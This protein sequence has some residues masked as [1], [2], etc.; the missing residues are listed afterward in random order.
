MIPDPTDT[1]V[2]K[3]VDAIKSTY[4]LLINSILSI[5][6]ATE[7][8]VEHR[9]YEQATLDSAIY[10]NKY[11][12]TAKPFRQHK[13]AGGGGRLE[14]L[15][16]ALTLVKTDGF[17]AEF[18]VYKGD[19]LSLIATRIDQVVYGF[20]SFEGLPADWFL[21][22]DKG[23]FSLQ[24]NLPELNIPQQNFRLVKGWFNDTLP[25]FTSQVESKAAFLHIDCDLYESTK[26]IFEG[27]DDRI[28]PGTI[29][30]F[31]EY[32]NYPGWQ[33]HEFRA[34]KEF[35]EKRNV[36]YKYLGF[37]PTMFSVAVLIESLDS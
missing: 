32:F 7:R 30:V 22:V 10:A 31:D 24:G 26:S 12:V 20:D 4:G 35:C 2:G 25:I 28:Q 27:L 19:T 3:F 9:M 17:F 6:K 37:A 36:S 14:L 18:G 11:M 16:Y 33:N 34:F 13:F 15:E 21:N 8:D 1:L 23:Y 29:I 5:K